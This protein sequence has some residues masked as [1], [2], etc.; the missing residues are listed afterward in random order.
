MSLVDDCILFVLLHHFVLVSSRSLR[1][2]GVDGAG[3]VMI[4]SR[5]R[6]R[7]SPRRFSAFIVLVSSTHRVRCVGNRSV[8]LLRFTLGL[9]RLGIF[10]AIDILLFCYFRALFF[11]R[12]ASFKFRFLLG[13]DPFCLRDLILDNIFFLGSQQPRFIVL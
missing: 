6:C 2:G 13:D 5:C 12:I 1:L 10:I 7:I 9:R 11:G 4:I 3:I 8:C